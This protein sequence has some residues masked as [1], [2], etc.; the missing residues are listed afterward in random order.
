MVACVNFDLKTF[1][2]LPLGFVAFFFFQ[3]LLVS[4]SCN[5]YC[6]VALVGPRVGN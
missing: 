5:E 3:T 2:P 4:F 1:P 6:T